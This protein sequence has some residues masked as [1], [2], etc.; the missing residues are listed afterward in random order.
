V[1][2]AVLVEEV[3]IDEAVLFAVEDGL[4]TVAALG[5][6]MRRSDSDNAAKTG[7]DDKTWSKVRIFSENVPSVPVF[8][9]AGSGQ[10]QYTD[11]GHW[12]IKAERHWDGSP[13]NLSRCPYQLRHG[14]ALAWAATALASS[15]RVLVRLERSR[16]Q[17]GEQ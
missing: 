1:Q 3:E 4:A 2:E 7:H 9:G 5:Y 16:C 6:V 13:A 17:P 11:P 12:S 14:A 15:G 8:P 10:P